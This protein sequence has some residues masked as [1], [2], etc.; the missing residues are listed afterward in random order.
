M[1]WT[2]C[3]RIIKTSIVSTILAHWFKNIFLRSTD[4]EQ[5]Y[6]A[7]WL[8]F[9]EICYLNALAPRFTFTALL[10]KRAWTFCALLRSFFRG[11]HRQIFFSYTTYEQNCCASEWQIPDKDCTVW[12]DQY[13]TY[14]RCYTVC[15][16]GSSHFGWPCLYVHN[17]SPKKACGGFVFRSAAV[18][19][20]S[21]I[22]IHKGIHW[23]FDGCCC[24]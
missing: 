2:R 20:F 7:L 17:S 19:I 24:L 11:L 3:L 13:V 16:G 22:S 14:I 6:F 5:W 8:P 21:F 4:G 10:S 15:R 1:N 12:P 9:L 18:I 23:E